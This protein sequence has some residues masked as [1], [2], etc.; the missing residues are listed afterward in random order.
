MDV[1][2]YQQ[3]VKATGS[4]S[5]SRL[6]GKGSHGSI[7]KGILEEN[8]L[9]AIKK[10]SSLGADHV[11]ADNT[12]K[13]ENEI[14]VLSSLRGSPYIINFLGASHYRHNSN[15]K[16]K[17]RVLVMEFMPNG[18]LHDLLHVDA[19]PPPWPKRV[20]IAI[21]IAR[22]KVIDVS[23]SPSSIVEWAVPLIEEQRSME[24]CDTRIALPTFM[25][26][27]IKHLLYVAARCVSCKEEN[28]PSFT[29]IVKGMDKNCLVERVQMLSWTSLMRSVILT[30]RPRELAEQWQ[31]TNCD[32][33]SC[34]IS[35]GKAYLWEI[36]ADITTLK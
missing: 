36:L 25:E 27:T 10:S 32:D 20:E 9:V 1:F 19:S 28:R 23:R 26:G 31:Q 29:E 14:S 11:S 12:K 6:L 8:K 5:P 2:D 17:N 33:T 24:I 18:S 21:Q 34:D 7:Y 15:C 35:E 4:F 22:A 30:R 3:L 13:L 16:E